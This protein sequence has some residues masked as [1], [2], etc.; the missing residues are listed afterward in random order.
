MNKDEIVDKVKSL[1]LPKGSYIV[2]G[3]CPMAAHGLRKSNDIDLLISPAL[4]NKLKTAGWRQVNKGPNDKPLVWDVFEAHDSWSFSA[5]K[6]TLSE[7]LGRAQDIDGVP[8]ASM[9][10]VRLWKLA[11]GRPKDIEDLKLIKNYYNRQG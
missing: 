5:Y 6:P 3:S 2:F 9:E 11:S 10:D 4:R 1:S 8:F 7:L